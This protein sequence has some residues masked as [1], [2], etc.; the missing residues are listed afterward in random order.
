MLQN[1][2][3]KNYALIKELRI[4]PSERFNIITGETGAGKSIMLGAVGLLLGKR[5]DTKVLLNEEEKCVIEASFHIKGHGLE[6][7]FQQAD[8]DYEPVTIIR[9]EI[10]P[11]GKSRAF[12]ND[13]PTT[14]E[15]LKK[16]SDYLVD[17]HSQ[18]DNIL[19]G[20]NKFQLGL[21]DD[22]AQNAKVRETYLTTYQAYI[23]ANNSYRHLLEVAQGISKEEDYMKFQLDELEK[24]DLQ[25]DEQATL[26][27][28]LKTLENAEEIKS[29]LHQCLLI[30]DREEMAVNGH[31]QTVASLLSQLTGISSQYETY[32]ERIDN[33]LIEL[34]D[35]TVDLERAQDVVEFNPERIQ[36]VQERISLIY[37]LQQKHH[38]NSIA[39]LL[40]IHAELSQKVNQAEN[41]E[42]ELL[43]AKK[44]KENLYEELLTKGKNLSESRTGC[45][46]G[47]EDATIELLKNLGMEDA[48]LKI[49]SRQV[50][51]NISG[52]DEIDILFSANKGISPQPLKKVASGGEFSRLLF[53]I[54]YLLAQ[55][56]ALPTMIFDEI[57]AG[58]SGEIAIKMAN[59]MK[60]M[61]EKHQVIAIS[62]LPQFA[63]KGDA[64]YFVFKDNSE[65]KAISKIKKLTQEE[66]V[67]EIAK[68]IGGEKPTATAFEN[69]RELMTVN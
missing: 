8:L 53:C 36:E 62:H 3:I 7:F 28:E 63:A 15:V 40:D 27:E 47:I 35:L 51:P 60:E 56:T 34:K 67:L 57:D 13:T 48:T 30:L 55:K 1:L 19:L 21:V 54:K 24:A 12:V 22:F 5:A 23:K 59:M 26:E 10:T 32:R 65:S 14:L 17:I 18:H 69:A 11:S 50:E 39:D 49:S 29:K 42:E 4:D 64:H 20:E 31:I 9:R 38:A 41:I 58:I 68:M 25:E 6:E 44:L 61:A 46:I 2:L 16:V 52:I 45:F 66:R 43:Q 37:R 33:C